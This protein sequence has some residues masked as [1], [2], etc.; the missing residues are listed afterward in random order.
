MMKIPLL[1]SSLLDRGAQIQPNNLLITRT[2]NGYSTITYREHLQRSK[3]LASALQAWGVKRGDRVATFCWNTNRHLQCYHAIP[4]M[5]AVLHTLNIRLSPKEQGYIVRFSEDRVVI[6]DFDLLERLAEVSPHDL[7]TVQLVVVC[8][9]DEKPGG[10]ENSPAHRLLASKLGPGGL[11]VDYDAFVSSASAA[12]EWPRDLDENAPLALCF[13][14]GTTGNPKGVVYSHRSQ[15][16]HTLCMVAPDCMNLAGKDTLL[17]VVPYFHANG[18]GLPFSALMLGARVVHNGRFTDPASILEMAVDWKVTFSAAV[19]TV[20]QTVRNSLQHEPE[21]YKGRFAIRQIS[22]G[23]SSPPNEMMKW[24]WDTYRTEFIQLW[25]MTE[26]SPCGTVARQV[27]TWAHAQ[28]TTDEQFKNV[29]KQGLPVFTVQMKIVDQND[30]SKVLPC[31]GKAQGEFLCYGPHVTG[32]YFKDPQPQ[33]FPNGWLATGDVAS[34]DEGYNMIIRDRSK[35]VIKSGG[36]WISSQDLEKHIAGLPQIL[37]AAVV[38]QEHPKWDERPIAIVVLKP[39]Q[40][41]TLEQV[42]DHC[43]AGGTFAKFELPDDL[44]FWAELPLTGTGKIDKKAIRHR[45]QHEKYLLPS[46]RTSKL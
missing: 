21:K 37:M 11:V 9:L 19:P 34:I 6:V 18:W 16:L 20:W 12:F 40:T 30:F 1:I 44:L 43:L 2:A 13:T 36:E 15:Y 5:G 41:V 27:A 24:F 42:H 28:Q 3:Q 29:T 8:G 7:A 22:C 14:S 10:W 45:L 23:G 35:D 38:A 31:D 17:P 25:G 39:S 26:L 46:L 33:K 4:C 32:S